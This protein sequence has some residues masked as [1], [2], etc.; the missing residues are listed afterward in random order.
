M[1]S[2]Q[3][4]YQVSKIRT[5]DLNV[6]TITACQFF[7][8]HVDC[9]DIFVPECTDHVCSLL[10]PGDIIAKWRRMTPTTHEDV[11]YYP[12]NVQRDAV[13]SDMSH[14]VSYIE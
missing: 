11:T 2:Q 8:G 3:Q 14:N 5:H 7:F 6:E 9:I 12:S 13:I 1:Y 10:Q 4:R